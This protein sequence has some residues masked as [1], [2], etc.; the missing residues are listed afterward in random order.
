MSIQSE[1][2]TLLLSSDIKPCLTTAQLS[3]NLHALDDEM[4][5]VCARFISYLERQGVRMEQGLHLS[6]CMRIVDSKLKGRRTLLTVLA[7]VYSHE[8]KDLF[9]TVAI[10]IAVITPKSG[11][12]FSLL[13]KGI[14]LR[15]DPLWIWDFEYPCTE[16]KVNRFELIDHPFINPFDY[17][18][19]R[20]LGESLS[21]RLQ[22][23]H[24]REAPQS[25]SVNSLI[26]A[27]A[28]LCRFVSPVDLEL[29]N[30]VVGNSRRM[31][32]FVTLP[33][34]TNSHH[35][36]R[37]GLLLH[38]VETSIHILLLLAK[39]MN[40]SDAIKSSQLESQMHPNLCES[41]A[42]WGSQV[43]QGIAAGILHDFGK[44][45]E[46]EDL[47]NGA[48]ALSDSGLF[49]G[50][51]L[52]V[53]LWVYHAAM[54]SGYPEP[55]RLLELIHCLSA[56]ERHHDQSGLRSRKTFIAKVV[57][58]ADRLSA[59][60][61][62]AFAQELCNCILNGTLHLDVNQRTHELSGAVNE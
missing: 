39:K 48:Y 34:S 53:C 23:D 44:I 58:Q 5:I 27:L 15:V 28:G 13:R 14:Y 50:H 43:A 6:M 8:G 55:D 42:G 10:K 4:P 46:Y 38:T 59:G 16:F 47:G 32:Q 52:K 31:R 41:Q 61:G 30:V 37:H 26:S 56:V 29:I 17:V 22:T 1:I 18:D 33:A 45:G 24:G 2:S 60:Q 3:E 11:V 19:R 25:I 54:S 49:L 51:Q 7:P 12:S 35:S 40:H 57:N 62:G 36:Y 21:P 20:D 9:I